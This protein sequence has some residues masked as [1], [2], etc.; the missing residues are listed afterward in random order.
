M[1]LRGRVGRHA[2]TGRQ[3]RNWKSDQ[4]AVIALLTKIPVADGGAEGGLGGRIIGGRAS[5]ALCQAILRFQKQ[6]FPSKQTGFVEPGGAVLAQMERLASRPAPSPSPAPGQWDALKTRSVVKGLAEG[7]ADD[8][9]LN[10][11]E[12]VNIIRSTLSDGMVTAKEMDDLVTVATASKTIPQRSRRMLETLVDKMRTLTGGKGPYS[13]PSWYHEE[14]AGM[15][16]DFLEGSGAS[17][18]PHLDRDEVGVGILMRIANPAIIRQDE[19]SLCGP[20]ALLFSVASDNPG[21]YTRYALDL[22]EKGKAR[23]GRLEI[24]P[25]EDCR[26][27]QP[28]PTMDHADWLTLASIRD[29]E[30]WFLDYD[31]AD[32]EM[33]GI[34][35]PMELTNWFEDSGY[36]DVRNETNLQPLVDEGTGRIDDASRLFANGYRICLFIRSEMLYEASQSEAGDIRSAHYVVL[37]SPID[38]SNGKIRMKV[39]TWGKGD[40]QVPNGSKDLS[41]HDFLDNFY[42]YVA[43]KPV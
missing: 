31:T 18:F 4:Q 26:S 3:C 1:P 34:T 35:S 14:A 7:L 40:Y 16:C 13:L 15:V 11:V 17:R 39:F 6:H 32:K 38:R 29:S 33:A 24:E 25:G 22:Y 19:A 21:A 8:S 42:G 9:K 2:K 41:L 12:V 30:N 36:T 28:P 43:A 23:L 5:E 20:A 37:R 10:H 27:Y